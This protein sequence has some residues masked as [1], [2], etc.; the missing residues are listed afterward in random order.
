MAREGCSWV[1]SLLPPERLFPGQIGSQ[2]WRML[3]V[4][5]KMAT[6][7]VV[8][9]IAED[10]SLS[11]L[12]ES[13]RTPGGKTHKSGCGAMSGSPWTFLTLHLVHMEPPAIRQLQFSYPNTGSHGGSCSSKCDSLCS[14]LCVYSFGGSGLPCDLN[15]LRYLR[16]VVDLQLSFL[17]VGTE[18]W[19]PNSLH[20][21]PENRSSNH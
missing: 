9:P 12:W 21:G 5:F 16:K 15:S 6:F 18:W 4:S 3:W 19:L 10:F 13:G 2:N 8:L 20:S 11:S 7:S 1:F 17:R 14:P